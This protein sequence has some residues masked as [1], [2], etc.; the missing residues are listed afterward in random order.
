VSRKRSSEFSVDLDRIEEGIAVLLAPEGYQWHLPEAFL[1]EGARE[2]MTLKV[3][4]SA[5]PASASARMERIRRL[6]EGLG[7]R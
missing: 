7:G 4:M 2:G 1:P 3:S 6:R 5:D